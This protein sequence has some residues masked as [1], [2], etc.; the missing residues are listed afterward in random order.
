MIRDW[1]N[2]CYSNT[3]NYNVPPNVSWIGVFPGWQQG[4]AK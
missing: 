3:T 1:G 2:V 4:K